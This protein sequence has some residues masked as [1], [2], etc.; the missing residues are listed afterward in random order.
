MNVPPPLSHPAVAGSVLGHLPDW[1]GA[2][3]KFRF[4]ARWPHSRIW[5]DRLSAIRLAEPHEHVTMLS[6]NMP[7]PPLPRNPLN[8]PTPHRPTF[9]DVIVAPERQALLGTR[10]TLQLDLFRSSSFTPFTEIVSSL[11]KQMG[12]VSEHNVIAVLATDPGFA[13]VVL[14]ACSRLTSGGWMKAMT[15]YTNFNKLKSSTLH[16]IVPRTIAS[17]VVRLPAVLGAPPPPHA[18]LADK[19]LRPRPASSLRAGNGG[20]VRTALVCRRFRLT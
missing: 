19:H 8:P 5:L 2:C 11:Y 4:R 10:V 7:D 18:S 15:R 20:Q 3:S 9:Y 12:V 16:V 6:S 14:I 17:S 13:R 1:L